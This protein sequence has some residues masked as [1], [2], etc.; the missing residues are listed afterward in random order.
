M[1]ENGKQFELSPAELRV[2]M[3]IAAWELLRQLS[4]RAVDPALISV[5]E[6]LA[7]AS[8]DPT[9]LEGGPDNGD[10]PPN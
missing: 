8:H 4:R 6:K 1:A 5:V 2:I 3:D 9:K 10:K 7:G